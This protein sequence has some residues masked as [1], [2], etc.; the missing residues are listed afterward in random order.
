MPE[1]PTPDDEPDNEPDAAEGLDA[2]A[3][4]RRTAKHAERVA[5]AAGGATATGA[6]DEP[7]KTDMSAVGDDG[8]VFGG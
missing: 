4:A 8:Q 3:R 2:V 6:Q 5:D 1:M 7:D